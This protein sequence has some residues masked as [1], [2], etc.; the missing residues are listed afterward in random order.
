MGG[1]DFIETMPRGQAHKMKANV[2]RKIQSAFL[3]EV[4]GLIGLVMDLSVCC[5]SS[6]LGDAARIVLPGKLSRGSCSG[7]AALSWRTSDILD[8]VVMLVPQIPCVGGGRFRSDAGIP[9]RRSDDYGVNTVVNLLQGRCQT[10]KRSWNPAAHGRMRDLYH[11]V[12]IHDLAEDSRW[13]GLS[14][15]SLSHSRHCMLLY[16]HALVIME[17]D[18]LRISSCGILDSSIVA[19]FMPGDFYSIY[20]HAVCC[21]A[22]VC[23]SAPCIYTIAFSSVCSPG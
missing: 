22:A 3:R 12:T 16:L 5:A 18:S 17:A 13:T 21:S 7:T 14:V 6:C 20:T 10:A 4:N 11:L 9:A 8:I 19:E 2:P 15:S 23:A 1:L